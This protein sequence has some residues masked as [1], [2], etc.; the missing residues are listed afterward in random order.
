MHAAYTAPRR[1][2][3]GRCQLAVKSE[4]RPQGRRLPL[5]AAAALW[6][7]RLEAR[8]LLSATPVDGS[9]DDANRLD[10]HPAATVADAA[11]DHAAHLLH[12]QH[13]VHMR[14]MQHM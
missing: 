1:G 14:H 7:Q 2:D 3:G 4:P 8:Q 11:A 5:R 9:Q 12:L 13:M 10:S 6:V